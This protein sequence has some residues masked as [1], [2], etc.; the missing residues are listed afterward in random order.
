MPEIVQ[1]QD[2]RQTFIDTLIELAE[3]DDR[4]VLI[5]PDVGFN[6]IE[7]FRE[8]FPDRFFNFGC[9]EA[10]T[11]MIA[12]GMALSGMRPFV[13]SMIN[14][15][16]FRPFEMVRNGI[17]MHKAAVVLL[18]VKGSSGY[19]FLGF[20][21]NMLFDDEDVY[22]LKPYIECYAPQTNEEVRDSILAA[23]AKG[24]GSYIRL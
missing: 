15:V 9:T 18:G 10:S 8:K 14:F 19:K 23:Y 7:K 13:Y 16:A 22:H 24:E 12:A 11:I 21:H 4:I 3:K 1:R 6:Y 17:A 2:S 5:V 20:S